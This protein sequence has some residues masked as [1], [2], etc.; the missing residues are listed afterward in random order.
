VAITNLSQPVFNS[1]A[2]SIESWLGKEIARVDQVLAR[3]QHFD[4]SQNCAYQHPH[5]EYPCGDPAS[6]T[7]LDSQQPLCAK[8]FRAVE[9]GT[10]LDRLEVR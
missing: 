1:F 3:H 4:N 6:V 10:A 9:L 5:F 8:H 7:D 2:Q